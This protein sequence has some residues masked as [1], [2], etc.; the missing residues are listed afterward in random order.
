MTKRNVVACGGM[1]LYGNTKR[2]R[3]NLLPDCWVSCDA[4]QEV[5]TLKL[6][7]KLVEALKLGPILW[8][9]V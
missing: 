8:K 2:S 7:L 6:T 1:M 5:N 9:I 4:L 3:I